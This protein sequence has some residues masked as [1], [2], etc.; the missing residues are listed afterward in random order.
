MLVTVSTSF[1]GIAMILVAVG[2]FGILMRSV[3]QRTR[4][5][6]IRVAL[7][8]AKNSILR[9]VLANAIKRVALGATIGIVLTVLTAPLL[10]ALLFETSATSPWIYV[11]AVCGLFTVAVCAAL[12]PAMRA[13]SIEPMQA[14]RSE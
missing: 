14:L 3:T 6:G 5:I 10:R 13:L 4:E 1:G 11:I 9:V 12:V 7:G 2:L 8:E